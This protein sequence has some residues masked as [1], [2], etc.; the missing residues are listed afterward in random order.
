MTPG[1]PPANP[2]TGGG[3]VADPYI[4]KNAADLARMAKGL[5]KY[6]KLD[7]SITI[8][9]PWTPIGPRSAP[10]TGVFDGNGKTITFASG[11]SLGTVNDVV[12][13]GNSRKGNVLNAG[14][15]GVISGNSSEVKNL[16]VA[17]SSLL[18]VISTNGEF[19]AGVIAG[20]L[21]GSPVINSCTVNADLSVSA[22]S[23]GSLIGGIAGVKYESAV[24]TGCTV[25]ANISLSGGGLGCSAGGIAGS[26]AGPIENCHT[27]GTVTIDSTRGFGTAG[28]IVGSN[29]GPIKNCHA[30]G[31]VTGGAEGFTIGG[32][33]GSNAGSIENSYST[34]AI[35]GGYTAGGIAGGNNS[36][37]EEGYF[38]VIST[39]YATGTVMADGSTAFET[40]FGSG[41]DAGG[42]VGVQ[43]DEY[44][45]GSKISNCV[46][47]NTG[48]PAVSATRAARRIVNNNGGTLANNWGASMTVTEDG[49][50]ITPGSTAGGED[51]ADFTNSGQ[52]SWSAA[53]GLG[54]A[55]AFGSNDAAP[56]DWDAVNNRPKL[57]WE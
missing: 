4:I 41:S 14:I 42:I 18:V 55:F 19:H 39:C 50:P 47:L 28:G 48:S 25:N 9:G 27:A 15:F 34:G 29:N 53:I 7:N 52:A 11:S 49:S 22:P 20:E 17:A 8:S 3:T 35:S 12:V 23:S 31:T 10:F 30:A 5:D 56:W 45:S 26:N 1:P 2:E 51:G 16:T 33:V 40:V 54:P 44:G 6:Y 43:D 21:R 24:I 36:D 13:Y 37:S 46:A 38:G 57:Y 32:I